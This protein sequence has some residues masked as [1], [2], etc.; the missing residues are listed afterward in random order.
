MMASKPETM[1]YRAP[2][3]SLFESHDEISLCYIVDVKLPYK[4]IW[5]T[6]HTSD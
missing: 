3:F 5:N 1:F 4:L 6:F 2:T